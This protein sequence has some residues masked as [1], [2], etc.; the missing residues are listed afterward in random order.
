MPS[1]GCFIIQISPQAELRL[2]PE[3]KA[4]DYVRHSGSVRFLRYWVHQKL[5]QIYTVI[6]YKCVGKVAWFALYICGNLW[7]A[8]YDIVV[9]YVSKVERYKNNKI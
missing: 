8:L 6:S 5:P 1:N 9:S 3:A 4:Q 2:P 7:N